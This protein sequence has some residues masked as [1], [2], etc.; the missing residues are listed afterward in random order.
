MPIGVIGHFEIPR[1]SRSLV[2][3][4]IDREGWRG[5]EGVNLWREVPSKVLRT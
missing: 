4:V 2:S 1:P 3:K 5:T